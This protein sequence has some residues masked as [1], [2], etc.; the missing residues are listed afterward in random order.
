M[1]TLY[2]NPPEA[3]ETAQDGVTDWSNVA[4]PSTYRGQPAQFAEPRP[5]PT[6]GIN[7]AGTL[8]MTSGNGF[9]SFPLPYEWR[10]N[11]YE[12]ANDAWEPS[13]LT[14]NG[15]TQAELPVGPV[16]LSPESGFHSLDSYLYSRYGE[17]GSQGPPSVTEDHETAPETAPESLARP[18]VR[19]FSCK[20]SGWCVYVTDH[21]SETDALTSIATSPLY[22]KN[23]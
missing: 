5:D 3:Y 10:P 22:E 14:D 18:I 1:S 20:I 7:S 16:G 17:A 12:W 23:T 6:A 9:D 15:Q 4:I 13:V 11:T 19:P 2:R 8:F 21:C